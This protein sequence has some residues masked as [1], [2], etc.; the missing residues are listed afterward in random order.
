MGD[1]LIVFSYSL[2][3][4]NKLFFLSYLLRIG[5]TAVILDAERYSMDNMFIIDKIHNMLNQESNYLL[6]VDGY[7]G[8]LVDKKAKIQCK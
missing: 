4:N 8:V 2:I 5:I 3:L 7:D 1:D 6:F